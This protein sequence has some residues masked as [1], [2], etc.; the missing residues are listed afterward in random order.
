VKT[1]F[2]FTCNE[3]PVFV[4]VN[5]PTEFT[6]AVFSILDED[7]IEYG[8]GGTPLSAASYD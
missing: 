8:Y 6:V 2:C 5:T 7:S 3:A 1:I 4:A